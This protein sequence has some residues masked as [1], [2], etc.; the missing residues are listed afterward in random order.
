MF[1][2][3]LFISGLKISS[4]KQIMIPFVHLRTGIPDFFFQY[5]EVQDLYISLL[6]GSKGYVI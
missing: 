6:F 3:L 4:Y 5:K 2:L 1:M